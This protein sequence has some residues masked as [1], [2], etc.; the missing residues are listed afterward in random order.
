MGSQYA[1]ANLL[2]EAA[3]HFSNRSLDLLTD[4]GTDDGLNGTSII[5]D[6]GI[7]YPYHTAISIHI[8][9]DFVKS[10]FCVLFAPGR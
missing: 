5:P 2:G 7:W 8:T 3:W 6:V 10:L 9:P 1:P 4:C